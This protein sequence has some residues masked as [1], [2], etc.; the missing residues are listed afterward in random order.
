VVI[1]E[2]AGASVALPPALAQEDARRY[3]DTQFLFARF[4]G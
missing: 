2:A 1:E 3:G 4:R